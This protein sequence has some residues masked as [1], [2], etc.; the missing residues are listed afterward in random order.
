MQA[1]SSAPDHRYARAIE[2]SRKVR[3]DIDADVIRGRRFD[4]AQKFLPDGLSLAHQLSFLSGPEQRLMSQ[5]QGRTYANMFGLVERFINAKVLELGQRHALGDQL[6]L[7]ALVRFSDEEL[8]HQALFRRIETLVAEALPSGYRFVLDPDA[9]AAAVLAKPNWSVLALTCL[10]ELFSQ[11]HYKESIADDAELSELFRDVFR[12]HLLEESQHALI[13][14]LEWRAMDRCLSEA[15]RDQGVDALIEL[16]GAVDSLV[17]AQAE[18]DAG[19]FLACCQRPFASQERGAVELTFFAAY[20][21]QYV[22]SGVQ[23]T[24]FPAILAELVTPQQL[25]RVVQA[26]AQLK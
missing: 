24:R 6:A 11:A 15:E 17:R 22:L 9:V 2:A 7:E 23:R 21:Y 20:R 26:L 10:I 3:W 13:D 18:A 14:E 5:V 25:A 8:K 12:F 1:S 4:P 19:F 16:V